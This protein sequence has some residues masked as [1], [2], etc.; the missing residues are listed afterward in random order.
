MARFKLTPHIRHSTPTSFKLHI[1]AH[2]T[3]TRRKPR[4]QRH[5]NLKQK[6]GS[7]LHRREDDSEDTYLSL[8]RSIDDTEGDDNEGSDGTDI[9]TSSDD[10]REGWDE[11]TALVEMLGSPEY[12]E[13]HILQA[14]S[15]AFADASHGLR[16]E[17]VLGLRPVLKSI[18]NIR[19]APGHA[20]IT[21][22][23]G[24]D[25]ACKHFESSHR[26]AELD[27]A[28][29]RIEVDV[30]ELF[31]RLQA[32]YSRLEE[33]RAT[34]QKQ[35]KEQTNKMREIIN[36]LPADADALLVKLERKYKDMDTDDGSV[37]KMK[38]RERTVQG[39]LAELRL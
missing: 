9:N 1:N 17:I 22:L 18:R 29:A 19:P 2:T 28:Y 21:G 23:L 13:E 25:D 32:A 33:K 36:T 37:T 16:E 12:N 3:H 15:R 30:G 20:F 38:G 10:K 35:V 11:E 34:F 7:M 39:A 5:L 27:A 4:Y 14:L 26:N 31:E 24:F 6:H 8:L